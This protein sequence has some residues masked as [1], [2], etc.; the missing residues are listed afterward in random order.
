MP[1][2]F[3]GPCGNNHR[4]GVNEKCTRLSERTTRSASAMAESARESHGLTHDVIDSKLTA[5]LQDLEIS[6]EEEELITEIKEIERKRRLE[7]L[8]ARKAALLQIP[9]ENPRRSPRGRSPTQWEAEGARCEDRGRREEYEDRGRSHR[10]RRRSSTDSRSRTPSL[11]RRR[12]SKWSV[13]R[14]TTDKKELK[15]LNA[16]ELIE[17]SC[18]WTIDQQSLSATDYR[19]FIKHIQ[20][21]AGKAKSDKFVDTTHVNYDLAI[22]KEA[23]TEGFGAF[24]GG[25]PEHSIAIYSVENLRPRSGKGN[26]Q[27]NAKTNVMSKDGKRPCYKFN[28][29]GCKDELCNFGHWCAKCGSKNHPKTKCSRD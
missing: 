2:K 9:E 11:E 28:G 13:K 10:R 20:Y 14:Y 24:K 6:K 18:K 17:A 8:L 3:C 12:R 4:G 23:E 25:D 15:K 29:T 5:A 19:G 26:Y 27:V 16:Y 1:D 22:R 7:S 21:I